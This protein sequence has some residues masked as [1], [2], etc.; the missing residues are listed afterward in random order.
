ML[1]LCMLKQHCG[2]RLT[3][4]WRSPLP[5][6]N[7]MGLEGAFGR[8]NLGQGP[9]D[10]LER[11]WGSLRTVYKAKRASSVRSAFLWEPP[12]ARAG[13]AGWAPGGDGRESA[14]F[15]RSSRNLSNSERSKLICQRHE[16]LISIR[17]VQGWKLTKL[18]INLY[19]HWSPLPLRHP[20]SIKKKKSCKII[21][22]FEQ[23]L[24]LME[25][26]LFQKT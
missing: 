25:S 5:V 13:W 19:L 21:Y 23:K 18:V 22:T 16:E 14:A 4:R 10:A 12:G 6:S 2:K 1:D 17:S 15:A 8:N 9:L 7:E 26:S 20:P 11:D 3:K 24:S